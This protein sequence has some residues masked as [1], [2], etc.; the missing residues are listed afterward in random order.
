MAAMFFF[1]ANTNTI[2]QDAYQPYIFEQQ[3]DRN[4]YVSSLTLPG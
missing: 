3:L 2:C 1:S 4:G